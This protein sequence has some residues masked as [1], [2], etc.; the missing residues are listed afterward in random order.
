[1]SLLVRYPSASLTKHQYDEAVRLIRDAGEFPPDG[2]EYH[3]CFGSNG[4]LEITEVWRSQ[5]QFETFGSWLRPVLD[6]V[7]VNSGEADLLEIHNI[8]RP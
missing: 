7:G 6:R 5:E 1:M 3:V 4:R 8:I 2:L